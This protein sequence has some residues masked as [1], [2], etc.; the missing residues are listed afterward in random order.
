MGRSGIVDQNIE[1]A[2]AVQRRIDHCL[3]V[4]TAGHVGRNGNSRR[5]D[6]GCHA[7]GRIAADVRH[8][9][10][11]P[12]LGEIMGDALAVAAARTGDDRDP[13]LKLHDFFS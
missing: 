1:L 10:L 5:A 8:H 13:V 2:E 9:D 3:G 7:F 6:I 4:I 11:G 12:L